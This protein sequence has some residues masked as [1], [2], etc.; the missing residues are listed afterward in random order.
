MD[1]HVEFKLASQYQAAELF[2]RFYSPDNV[3]AKKVEDG[4]DRGESGEDSGYST[5]SGELTDVELISL[6]RKELD[7]AELALLGEKFKISIPD[8]E[9]SMAALQGYLMMYKD[10]PYDAVE[11]VEAWVQ[12]KEHDA[13]TVHASAPQDSSGQS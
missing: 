13:G 9:I 1:V 11:S 7:L 12:E 2:K 4:S 5:P 6:H 10:R 3:T 8:R